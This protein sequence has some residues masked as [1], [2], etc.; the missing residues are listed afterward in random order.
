MSHSNQS[1]TDSFLP[2]KPVVFQIL[3]ILAERER[4]GYGILQAVRES[5]A[6]KIH[7]E[8]GPL[9]RC[10][11]KLLDGGLIEELHTPPDPQQDD[12]RRRCYYRLTGLGQS[13]LAAEASRLEEL[14]RHSRSLGIVHKQGAS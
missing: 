6:G 9:Y 5:S 4:H 8:T 2:L 7:L 1:P 3:L 14:L 13:V 10:L 12:P 11:K